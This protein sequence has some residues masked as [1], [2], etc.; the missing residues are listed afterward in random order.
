M[1]NIINRINY[2]GNKL[3]RYYINYNYSEHLFNLKMVIEINFTYGPITEHKFKINY[4]NVYKLKRFIKSIKND[5]HLTYLLCS[6]HK[7]ID[8]IMKDK[9][10]YQDAKKYFRK[11]KLNKVI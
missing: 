1:H 4:Y 6:K 2:D 8:N 10:I 3:Q 9:K 7:E 11:C 5:E